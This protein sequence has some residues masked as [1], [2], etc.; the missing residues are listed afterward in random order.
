MLVATF[1]P[2]TGWAGKTITR[3]GDVF[4]LEGH[5]PITAVDV[6]EYDRQGHLVWSNEGTRAWVG[7]KAVAAP[8]P[9]PSSGA[10]AAVPSTAGEPSGTTSATVHGAFPRSPASRRLLAI[11][12][13]SLAIVIVVGALAF[14]GVFSA[15]EDAVRTKSATWPSRLAGTWL[16]PDGAGHQTIVIGEEGGRATLT[17]VQAD[18]SNFSYEFS[19]DTLTVN[20][21]PASE[22]TVFDRQTSS[23]G[24]FAGTYQAVDSTLKLI[25]T[26]SGK[27]LGM[28]TADSSTGGTSSTTFAIS[29]DGATLT[30]SDS[31]EGVTTTYARQ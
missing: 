29:D 1:G 28:A 18:G 31:P 7:S 8:M 4:T 15:K 10:A 9:A 12:G 26:F 3:E 16:A 20:W 11:I 27:V 21:S 30:S 22:A 17:H 25:V 13:A 24:P 5:G 2:T 6:M 19:G 23:S 14:A